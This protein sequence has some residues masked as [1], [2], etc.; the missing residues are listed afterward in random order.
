MII[1]SQIEKL[2]NKIFNLKFVLINAGI[3]NKK[4]PSRYISDINL[5]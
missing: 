4:T 1:A 2:I 3:I 5:L